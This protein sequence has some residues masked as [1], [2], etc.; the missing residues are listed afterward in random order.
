MPQVKEISFTCAPSFPRE[1]GAAQWVGC[2]C[3][4]LRGPSNL[5]EPH[6][7][8]RISILWS[9]A[10]GITLLDIKLSVFQGLWPH[11]T[12]TPTLEP[13]VIC[14]PCRET[15][16]VLGS[17]SPSVLLLLLRP[18]RK[19]N[20]LQQCLLCSLPFALPVRWGRGHHGPSLREEKPLTWTC[21]L[22][23]PR[24]PCEG[25]DSQD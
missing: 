23:W 13:R 7:I 2:S 10:W 12:P 20:L 19:I 25:M 17:P 22:A 9:K 8:M 14:L 4:T 11:P 21:E 1:P 24:S 6:L 5:S 3:V 16:D 18:S 15:S